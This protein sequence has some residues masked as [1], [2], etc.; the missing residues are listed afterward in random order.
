MTH[1]NDSHQPHRTR[2]Q[3]TAALVL[4][5]SV[6]WVGPVSAAEPGGGG[7]GASGPIPGGWIQAPEAETRGSDR[8]TSATD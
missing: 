1:S 5:A 8:R 6:G 2:R 4:L 3:E 7:T